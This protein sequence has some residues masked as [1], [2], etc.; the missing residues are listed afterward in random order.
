MKPRPIP[1][2]FCLLCA[3]AG[4]GRE[5]PPAAETSPPLAVRIAP[6]TKKERAAGEEVVGTVRPK[7][8]AVIEAKVS[9]RI[10]TLAVTPG[11]KVKAGDL[12]AQLD[13][14]EIQARLD[15]ARAVRDQAARE[16]ERARKLFEQKITSQAEFDAV[17]AR[18]RVAAGAATEAETALGYLKIV[19]PF[20]GVVTR[21]LADVGDLAAPGKP[22]VEMEDPAA[23]RF[24]AGVP[25]ALIGGIKI[26]GQLPVRVSSLTSDLQGT[27]VEIAPVA[28]AASR[29][30][31]VK[32][33]LPPMDAL[34]SGQF[35]RVIVP[36][37]NADSIWVPAP[38]VITRGQM[39][40][41]FVAVNER[42]QLRLVRTGKRTASEVELLAGISAGENVVIEGA[43]QLRDGQPIAA[44]P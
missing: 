44:K 11:Q 14:R 3:L 5:Q 4:C 6:V 34:R 9:G 16:L 30:Y 13:A 41:V 25:E 15:Q 26:A 36:T 43:E 39:E 42:A 32:L 20:N 1:I 37:G 27:V 2:A 21:K 22:I 23:L 8:Q 38:A 17:Q 7:L 35:G 24:E 29:T 31:L 40:I 12:L 33:D 28:D 10:E 18:E 19:A